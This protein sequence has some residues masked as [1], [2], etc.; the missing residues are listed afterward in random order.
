MARQEALS[1]HNISCIFCQDLQGHTDATHQKISIHCE[2]C[3]FVSELQDDVTKHKENEHSFHC[4]ACNLVFESASDFTTHKNTEHVKTT[5]DI[6]IRQ[7]QEEAIQF[8]CD[9]CDYVNNSEDE[10]KNH[11][12]LNDECEVICSTDKDIEQ[13]KKT[14]HKQGQNIPLQDNIKYPCENCNTNFNTF[15][16]LISHMEKDYGMMSIKKEDLDKIHAENLQLKQ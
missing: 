2:K 11:T 14:A 9:L 6:I 4:D 8:S 10:V 13:H 3:D 7:T 1:K 15:K 16:E 12:S 5:P